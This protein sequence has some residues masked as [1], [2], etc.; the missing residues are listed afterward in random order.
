MQQ[1]GVGWSNL[2]L[3]HPQLRKKRLQLLI[4]VQKSRREIRDIS[5]KYKIQD[6]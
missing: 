4:F 2:T 1:G 6:D 5:P 3:G